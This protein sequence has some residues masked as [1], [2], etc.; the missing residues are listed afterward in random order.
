MEVPLLLNDYLFY[1]GQVLRMIIAFKVFIEEI[2]LIVLKVF[3]VPKVL[4][5]NYY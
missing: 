3:T 4:M 5:E 1:I 2:I